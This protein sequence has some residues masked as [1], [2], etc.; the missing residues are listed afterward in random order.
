MFTLDSFF[1]DVCMCTWWRGA[2]CHFLRSVVPDVNIS[3][4]LESFHLTSLVFSSHSRI[5]VTAAVEI[6]WV[7]NGLSVLSYPIDANG[8]DSLKMFFKVKCF[9]WT[10]W[11]VCYRWF[12]SR[13]PKS[14]IYLRLWTV[15]SLFSV[16]TNSHWLMCKQVYMRKDNGG[17]KLTF[18]KSICPDFKDISISWSSLQ[19]TQIYIL[20]LI[21]I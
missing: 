7:L 18:V 8:F 12:S 6:H 19:V 21:S 1:H 20:S 2:S 11:P 16:F 5:R 14:N 13:S 9:L 15:C 17:K 4:R 10:A 3:R